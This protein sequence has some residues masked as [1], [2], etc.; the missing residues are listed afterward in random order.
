M[1]S[2]P[3]SSSDP[4]QNTSVIPHTSPTRTSDSTFSSSHFPSPPPFFPDTPL[5]ILPHIHC[6]SPLSSDLM[7]RLT[8]THCIVSN[9]LFFL[10]WVFFFLNIH[11]HLSPEA[12]LLTHPVRRPCQPP[13]VE[14]QSSS[15]CI[16]VTFL[17][18]NWWSVFQNT[19][20]E[21]V[22]KTWAMTKDYTYDLFAYFKTVVT[23][24]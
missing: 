14:T 8:V 11:P 3:S 21:I 20:R 12:A 23:H 1:K 7:I 9:M 2:F 13:Q 17:Q 15:C 19:G 16:I 4:D 10:A 18:L 24:K 5:A 22:W 6:S